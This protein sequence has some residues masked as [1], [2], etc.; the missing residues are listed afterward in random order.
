MNLKHKTDINAMAQ[1]LLLDKE[2]DLLG[3]LKIGQ[4]IVKLQGRIIRPFQIKVPEFVVE[5]G[6]VTDV[7]IQERMQHIAPA[8]IE[9]NFSHEHASPDS[10]LIQNT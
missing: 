6:K 10:Y 2:K 1:C 8:I 3:T 7:W 5:K 9:T 4:A